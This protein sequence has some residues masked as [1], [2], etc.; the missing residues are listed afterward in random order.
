MN[1]KPDKIHE[2]DH[3]NGDSLNNKKSNLRIITRL[4]NI[5]NAKA[6]I[7]NTT[8]GIRGIYINSNNRYIISFE[9][10][11]HRF[12]FKNFSTLEEAV[13]LRYLCEKTFLKNIKYIDE[14]V[15][16]IVDNLDN[17]IKQE[18]EI[19]FNNKI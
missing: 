1:F 10:N 17:S 4:E 19:Y 7:D 2:V 5:Q 12:Y 18:I 13:Y 3:I 9:F 11:K 14:E 8:T 6:R 16:N 15:M